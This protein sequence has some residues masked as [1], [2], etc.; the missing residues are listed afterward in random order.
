V[1]NH[2]I[3]TVLSHT[4]L[5]DEEDYEFTSSLGLSLVKRQDL[6]H[7]MINTK[8][9]YK[10]YL[11]RVLLKVEAGNKIVDHINHNG[12]DCRRS[13]LRVTDKVGNALNM[14]VNKTKLSGL[15][16][17]VYK[18][19]AGFKAQIRIKGLDRYLG[20]FTTVEKA[21]EAYKTANEKYWSGTE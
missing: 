1:G 21:E 12:L 8:P 2:R 9:Y 17:G 13:N 10:K 7:V 5:V 20:H 4:I 3:I 6:V 16:K 14:R 19:R 11:H 18:E 15:P